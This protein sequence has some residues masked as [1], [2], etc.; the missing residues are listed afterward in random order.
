MAR[1]L[2]LTQG[3]VALVDDED[4]E[5]LNR[6]S[7]HAH[8]SS[9]NIYAVRRPRSGWIRLHRLVMNAPAGMAVDH[10]DGD[11]L[12]CTKANLRIC[13]AQHNNWNRA[14]RVDAAHPY[15][16]IQP[17]R[18]KWRARICANRVIENLG[19]YRTAEEAA[20]AYDAAAIRLFG[21]FARLNF[22]ASPEEVVA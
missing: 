10:R 6:W 14:K 17:H 4:F 16:G 13:T 7:W 3:Y 5:A 22:P 2:P 20:R 9:T 1:E 8:A 18:R 12:N 11:T 21:E 19:A 15:K